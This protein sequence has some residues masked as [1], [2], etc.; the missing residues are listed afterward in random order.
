M[1]NK[2]KKLFATDTRSELDQYL[3]TKEMHTVQDVEFWTQEF[4]NRQRV[5]NRYVANGDI[6]NAEHIKRYY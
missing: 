1:L 3:S 6:Y 5:L 4:D 2:L